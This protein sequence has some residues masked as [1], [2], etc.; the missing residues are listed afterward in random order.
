VDGFQGREKE[1]IL[2]STVRSNAKGEVGFLADAR[3]MNVA[4]TRARRQVTLVGDSE[5]LRRDAFLGRLLQHF[6][7]QG[8]YISAAELVGN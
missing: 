5:C 2:I 4:V 3:R 1:A 8:E 7:G 6:E